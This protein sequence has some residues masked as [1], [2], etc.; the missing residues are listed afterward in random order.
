MWRRGPRVVSLA[1]FVLLAACDST[2][3][4]TATTT[5]PDVSS[6]SA[7][8]ADDPTPIIVD[9]SPTVSDVGGLMYLLAHP[10]V[11]VV[12][13]T[14]PGTGEAGCELGVDVTLR[15]LVM[16]DREEI[17]VACDSDIPPE[18]RSWPE[19]FL[20]GHEN[21][22][23]GLPEPTAGPSELAGPDL[24][25]QAAA[26]AVRPVVIYAVAPL[27]NV[28]RALDRHPS[29]ADRV[30]R[31]V[32]MG[33]AVDTPGNVLDAN[34]EWNLW[35]DVAAA[36]DV[37][38]SGVPV[39]LVPLDATNSVPVPSGYQDMLEEAEQSE[40]IVYLAEVVRSSPQVNSGFWYFW[41]ELAA[42]IVAGDP[43]AVTEEM[44]IAV[45]EGGGEDGRTVRDEAGTRV[46]VAVEVPDPMSFYAEFV[47]ML[48]GARSN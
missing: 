35:I 15:I 21:L 9:Y 43:N 6:T 29:L 19:E 47:E 45:V 7:A 23:S 22:L 36:A 30:E 46:T 42:T 18:A 4:S 5:T 33:G 13:V 44:T 40:A 2:P 1:L 38:A 39:T 26:T 12:A 10:D 14:L 32:I 16:F 37:I 41:D 31:I 28:A 3:I 17:P 11:D 34:A 24:I 25:A 48:A 8:D 20:A 27:T